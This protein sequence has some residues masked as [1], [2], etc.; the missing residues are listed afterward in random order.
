MLGALSLWSVHFTTKWKSM[1]H[2]ERNT[3]PD[4]GDAGTEL[5]NER[6]QR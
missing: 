5:R 1:S 3:S 2:T 4:R 6:D